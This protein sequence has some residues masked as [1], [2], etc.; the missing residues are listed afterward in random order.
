MESFFHTL[1]TELT[2]HEKYRTQE[3]ARRDIIESIEIFYN[4]Q[5]LL[6]SLGSKTP[7]EFEQEFQSAAYAV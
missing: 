7:A 3:E 1:K 5:R 4:R 2:H 6:S